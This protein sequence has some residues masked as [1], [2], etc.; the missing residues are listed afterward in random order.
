ME[1]IVFALSVSCNV[2]SI[3]YKFSSDPQSESLKR[4][5]LIFTFDWHDRYGDAVISLDT[6]GM[7]QLLSW[8]VLGMGSFMLGNMSQSLTHFFLL[9]FFVLFINL[10][11]LTVAV[12]T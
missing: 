1:I 9:I 3:G 6:A 8:C 7:W 10:K 4:L 12:C 5:M 11:L 2:K